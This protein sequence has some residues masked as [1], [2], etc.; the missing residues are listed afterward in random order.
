MQVE[1]TSPTVT[2]FEFTSK[3]TGV[4]WVKFKQE[5]ALFNGGKYPETFELSRGMQEKG[6][7]VPPEPY[8]CGMY[9]FDPKAY[10]VSQFGD[11]TIDDRVDLVPV[12][13]SKL[14]AA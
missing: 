1:I 13:D 12:K 10:K 2:R 7:E 4:V 9:E 3:K 6:R 8:A 14:R 11:I 5:A